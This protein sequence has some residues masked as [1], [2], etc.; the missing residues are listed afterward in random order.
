VV[1][2]DGGAQPTLEFRDAERRFD[3]RDVYGTA[4]DG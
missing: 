4:K 1:R 3:P 2:G